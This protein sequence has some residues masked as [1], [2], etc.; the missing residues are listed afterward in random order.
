MPSFSIPKPTVT[1][2]G[3]R[4]QASDDIPG[5]LSP[6]RRDAL[7]G[8]A[9]L[10]P[11]SDRPR[12]PYESMFADPATAEPDSRRSR[13]SAADPRSWP[14]SYVHAA[15]ISRTAPAQNT[16]LPGPFPDG[17]ALG[18]GYPSPPRRRRPRF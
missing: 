10:A 4:E 2:A 12:A 5:E 7:L 13:V 6:S 1:L 15:P 9:H 16:D 3:A 18:A 8:A 14:P 11:A 17:A